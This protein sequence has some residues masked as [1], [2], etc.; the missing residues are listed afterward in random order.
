MRTEGIDI[1]FR[2]IED[3]QDVE[4]IRRIVIRVSEGNIIVTGS[5]DSQLRYFI[6]LQGV[7]EEIDTWSC[8]FRRAESIAIIEVIANDYVRIG[9]CNIFIP[10][11]I[12]DVEVHSSR[13]SMEIREIPANVLAISDRGDISISNAK[14]VEV[15]SVNGNIIVD[16]S[17]G[18]SARSIN[19]TI[20]CSRIAGSV[21]VESQNSLVLMD[22]VEK[23]V[24]G[25]MRSRQN[26]RP[27]SQRKSQAHL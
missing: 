5:E 25:G 8:R 17:E 18:C 22:Q 19:G 7:S 10:S 23:N 21:Q 3:I 4:G 9:K 11:H 13:G 2:F 1:D 15:S 6:E 12:S 27:Q 24:A 20:R 16:R 14:F 26:N